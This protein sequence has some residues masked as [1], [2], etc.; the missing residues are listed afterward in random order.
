MCCFIYFCAFHSLHKATGVL[1]LCLYALDWKVAYLNIG[2]K[3]SILG[4]LFASSQ[5]L[6]WHHRD[7]TNVR[8]DKP[9]LHIDAVSRWNWL[10]WITFPWTI[11][12]EVCRIL[13]CCHRRSCSLLLFGDVR[14][15]LLIGSDS[16]QFGDVTF[17]KKAIPIGILPSF[18]PRMLPI[19]PTTSP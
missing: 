10:Y 18:Y 4:I 15:P 3:R 12:G 9:G 7:A 1:I 6:Y 11:I 14:H 8:S 2:V 13:F 19:S 5:H 16:G 17:V